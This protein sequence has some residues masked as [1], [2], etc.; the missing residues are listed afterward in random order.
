MAAAVLLIKAAKAWAAGHGGQLPGSYA[1]RGAFKELVRGWQRHAIDGVPL[2]VRRRW[3]LC[4][5]P[6][7]ARALAV[8]RCIRHWLLPSTSCIAIPP[9]PP[10][11]A[12][13]AGGKLH[14]GRRQR[15]QGVG[16]AVRA[17]RADRHPGRPRGPGHHP[18]GARTGSAHARLCCRLPAR[19]PNAFGWAALEPGTRRLLPFPHRKTPLFSPTAL[20]SFFQ[21]LDFWVLVAALKRFLEGEGGGQLPLEVN[22]AGMPRHLPA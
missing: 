5:P 14:R 3:A 1:E 10:L 2:E 21:S 6:L 18:A 16:A 4:P 9:L 15:A 13:I 8:L 12:T 20:L 22:C 7:P 11:P 17:P 19:P